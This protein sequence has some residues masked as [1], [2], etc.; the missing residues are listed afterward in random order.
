MA[1]DGYSFS[2]TANSRNTFRHSEGEWI[3]TQY[4]KEFIA[5]LG[6]E[7]LKYKLLL[8]KDKAAVAS[9]QFTFN[10]KEQKGLEYIT[11]YR[12]KL[13]DLPTLEELA[14][15]SEDDL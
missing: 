12:Q 14:L 9:M 8:A 7:T 4:S 1:G 10:A 3:Q 13:K 2:R 15:I 6:A 11:N 5:S